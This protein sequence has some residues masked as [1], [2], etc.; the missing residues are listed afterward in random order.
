MRTAFFVSSGGDSFSSGVDA[1]SG[2][3]ACDMIGCTSGRLRYWLVAQA[4]D[5][6]SIV[7]GKCIIFI[8]EKEKYNWVY[9][10]IYGFWCW[11]RS[12]WYFL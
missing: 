7:V 1:G 8:A 3:A 5:C 4:D 12:R 9:G 2:M 11:G 6:A 10:I